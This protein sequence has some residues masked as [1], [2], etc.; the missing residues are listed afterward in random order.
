VSSTSTAVKQKVICLGASFDPPH[1]A[2]AGMALLATAAWPDAYLWLLPSP[3][4]W[5]KRPIAPLQARLAWCHAFAVGLAQLGVRA[6]VSNA[7][8]SDG[9]PFRGT[10]TL[11]ESLCEKHP[12]IEFAF[13][14]GEDALGSLPTWRDPVANVVN[15]LRL[16]DLVDILFVPRAVPQSQAAHEETAGN[17]LSPRLAQAPWMAHPRIRSLPRLATVEGRLR[18]DAGLRWDLESLSSTAVRRSLASG[19]GCAGWSF[20]EVE[21]AVG[22]AG[23][24][25][26][27]V[28]SKSNL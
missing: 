28:V 5:D 4:R 18:S 3:E 25:A 22:D 16:P 7:E 2:H 9:A 13:L 21:R 8:L 6:S 24:Y 17:T 11:F 20:A 23:A 27:S 12:L 26:P 10:V 19:H 14:C 15:G 1:F